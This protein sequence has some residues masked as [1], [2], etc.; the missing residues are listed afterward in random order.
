MQ[1]L[2]KHMKILQQFQAVENGADEMKREQISIDSSKSSSTPAPVDDFEAVGAKA[3]VD[4][5]TVVIAQL[6]AKI[7]EVRAKRRHVETK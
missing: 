3:Q 7:K 1:E 5:S 2:Q 4:E 6:K